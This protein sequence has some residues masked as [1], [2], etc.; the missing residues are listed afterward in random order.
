MSQMSRATFSPDGSVQGKTRKVERSGVRYMS[1]SSMRTKP[2]M[3]DPSKSTR[4]SSAC[5]N[6]RCGTS[7]F[8]MTPRMSVNCRR[9]N[10]T[11]AARAA[12]STWAFCASCPSFC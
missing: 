9:M 6:R 7:T 2:S 8:L 5:S 3:D 11:P 4:P 12:S 10:R 1:D